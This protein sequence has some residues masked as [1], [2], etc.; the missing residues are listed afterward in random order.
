M[1]RKPASQPTLLRFDPDC[2]PLSMIPPPI[3]PRFG[4]RA[5]RSIEAAL[6][7]AAEHASATLRCLRHS[8]SEL[9]DASGEQKTTQ[10]K[11][12]AARQNQPLKA[13]VQDTAGV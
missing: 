11:G 10:E 3:S 9:R 12:G 1:P 6:R 2:S 4:D 13:V 5:C 7:T 8:R